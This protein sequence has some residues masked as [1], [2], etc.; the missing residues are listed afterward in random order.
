MLDLFAGVTRESH[1]GAALEFMAVH[2][3]VELHRGLI[4]VQSG[5]VDVEEHKLEGNA[6][7]FFKSGIERFEGFLARNDLLLESL[8]Y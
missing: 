4:T 6:F 2:D 3:L 1:N 5:H 7:A 8:R